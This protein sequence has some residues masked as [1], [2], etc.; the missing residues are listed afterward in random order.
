[1]N[2]LHGKTWNIREL[3]KV[4][5]PDWTLGEEEWVDWVDTK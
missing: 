3:N 2:L 5:K 4:E 1:M